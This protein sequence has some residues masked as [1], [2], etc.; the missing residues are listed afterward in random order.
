MNGA[1][2][3]AAYTDCRGASETA[4]SDLQ[5]PSQ[6]VPPEDEQENPCITVRISNVDPETT[7]D[8]FQAFMVESVLP[9]STSSIVAVLPGS[10]A[11]GDVNDGITF[12][13]LVRETSDADELIAYFNAPNRDFDGRTLHAELV[14]QAKQGQ[15]APSKAVQDRANSSD[16]PPS[17]TKICK[18]ITREVNKVHAAKL[19]IPEEVG[20]NN[21]AKVGFRDAGCNDHGDNPKDLTKPTSSSLTSTSALYV[22]PAKRATFQEPAHRLPEGFTS[23]ITSCSSNGNLR[24]DA[25]PFVPLSASKEQDYRSANKSPTELAIHLD[26]SAASLEPATRSRVSPSRGDKKQALSISIFEPGAK[27]FIPAKSYASTSHTLAY[28]PK[29]ASFEPKGIKIPTIHQPFK[30]FPSYFPTNFVE[31]LHRAGVLSVEDAQDILE[32][33]DSVFS[34]VKQLSIREPEVLPSFA[35]EFSLASKLAKLLNLAPFQSLNTFTPSDIDTFS[36][37]TSTSLYCNAH[38]LDIL[39]WSGITFVEELEELLNFPEAVP[40]FVERL[41]RRRPD[42]MSTFR[43]TFDLSN[44]LCKMLGYET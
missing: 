12:N 29:A 44:R 20:R 25:Q 18:E 27:Y 15:L 23:A 31:V 33:L 7:V 36:S 6:E 4:A 2:I 30:P 11:T 38:C 40:V 32:D 1:H 16:Q 5:R 35:T 24:P 13:V 26:V 28:N 41:A 10:S 8:D 43:A 22:P 19:T 42:A 9:E 17:V 14:V 34:F 37:L 3:S 39:Q 21:P